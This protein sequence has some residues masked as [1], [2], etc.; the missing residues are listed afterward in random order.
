M[1]LSALTIRDDEF[2]YQGTLPSDD[3]FFL[4]RLKG[5]ERNVFTDVM[6]GRQT[7]QVAGQLLHEFANWTGGWGSIPLR[8]TDISPNAPDKEQIVKRCDDLTLVIRYALERSDKETSNIYL[9]LRIGRYD[10]V[11]EL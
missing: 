10:L 1:G 4:R 6:I 5:H 9:D 8:L 2:S 3:R 11:A 7:L